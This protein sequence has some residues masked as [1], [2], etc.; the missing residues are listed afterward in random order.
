MSRL[1]L[2]APSWGHLAF[3]GAAAA[4][5]IWYFLDAYGASSRLENLMLIAPATAIGLGLC[6]FLAAAEFVTVEG[7]APRTALP[8]VDP[9]VPLFMALLAAY[10]AALVYDLGFDVASFL[11]LAASLWVLGERRPTLLVVFPAVFTVLIVL[12]MQELLSIPVPT[13]LFDDM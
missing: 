1:R 8:A 7:A 5:L 6:L 3:I 10:V 13:L 9:R 11:F 4:F 2:R 12:G